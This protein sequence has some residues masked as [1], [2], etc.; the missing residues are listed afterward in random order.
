MRLAVR[1]VVSVL[2]VLVLIEA[3]GVNAAT[4]RAIP[5]DNDPPLVNTGP[6]QT[7]TYPDTATM[8]ATVTDD[9]FLY[10]VPV[11]T[12]SGPDGVSFSAVDI[13]DPVVTFPGPGVYELTLTAD[14]GEFETVGTITVT[15]LVGGGD[16]IEEGDF[17]TQTQGGWGTTAHGNNPGTYRDEHF[18]AA[19]PSGLTIGADA[20]GVEGFSATFSS[21][22]AIEAFLPQ[23]GKPGALKQD[24]QDP[25]S[26]EAGV[27]AGQVVALELS[28]GFD[29]ADPEFGASDTLLGDLVVADAASPFVGMTVQQ[30]LDEAHK[31]LAGAES[32]FTASRVNEAVTAINENFVDGTAVGELLDYSVETLSDEEWP[33]ARG[34]LRSRTGPL[35]AKILDIFDSDDDGRLRRRERRAFRKAFRAFRRRTR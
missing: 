23:G 25:T 5:G 10:D 32:A 16:E 29:L 26:T 34:A 33:Q 14:D 35:F 15:V 9:G 7:I 6:D 30:V 31:I 17:R 8:A 28:V 24:H 21:S 1:S 20:V 3:Q 13:E 4:P 19:F 18:A 11:I 2:S 22:A 27:L 12:W